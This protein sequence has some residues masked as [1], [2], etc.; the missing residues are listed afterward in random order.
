MKYLFIILRYIIGYKN[1]VILREFYLTYL[2][3]L[4]IYIYNPTFFF[5]KIY[6]IFNKKF[7]IFNQPLILISQIQRSGGTLTSQLFD[8]HPQ[9]L[10]YPDELKI[11]EPKWNWKKFN[12]L[13]I[14]YNSIGNHAR[15]KH[16]KKEDKAQ[17]KKGYKFI[18]NMDLQRLI[19][20]NLSKQN[21]SDRSR[22]N[23]YFTSFFNSWSNYYDKKNLKKKKFITAF[24]PRINMTPSSIKKYFRIY[25]DGYLISII[26]DPENWY[27]SAKIHSNSY[28]NII[29]SLKIWEKSVKSSVVLKKKYKNKV[30]I[31]KFDDLIN[32]PEKTMKKIC[33][34]IDIKYKKTLAKP[35][36]NKIPILSNSSFKAIEGKIDKTVLNRK[37]RFRDNKLKK[38]ISS[39]DKI[40]K[41]SLIYKI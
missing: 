19:F 3:N 34:I 8:G 11:S 24:C 9:L 40:Y 30:I 32:F 33:K 15:L 38:I 7:I 18:C 14:Q 22:L 4:V 41:K 39:Y 13:Y 17:W 31:V 1:Y 25:E 5:K 2:D 37:I 29:E 27:S 28:S 36:F 6:F 16:Y 23:N 12:R 10:C 21:N 26:R 20:N 35:T